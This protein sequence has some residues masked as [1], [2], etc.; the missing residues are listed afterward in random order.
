MSLD[1][2]PERRHV[3]M[4]RSMHMTSVRAHFVPLAD[5]ASWYGARHYLTETGS[6]ALLPRFDQ[7]ATLVTDVDRVR[8]NLPVVVRLLIDGCQSGR[9]Q[10]PKMKQSITGDDQEIPRAG[11]EKQ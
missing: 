11:F 7:E 6:V 8:D 5:L 9:D 10:P 2:S 3:L 4:R 1:R